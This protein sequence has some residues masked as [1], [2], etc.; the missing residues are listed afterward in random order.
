MEQSP[1]EPATISE[2][3][4][5]R[6][7]GFFEKIKLVL[8]NPK[9]FFSAVY[10]EKELLPPVIYFLILGGCAYA[11]LFLADLITNIA[12]IS[13]T[14]QETAVGQ[15]VLLGGLQAV[16]ALI[17]IPFSIISHL[18]FTFFEAGIYSVMGKIFHN[19]KP[20]IQD[21][22][23][24]AYSYTPIFLFSFILIVPCLGILLYMIAPLWALFLKTYGLK[25][26]KGLTTSQA[27]LSVLIPFSIWAILTIVVVG[28][29]LSL[30]AYQ[31][32]NIDLT[33]PFL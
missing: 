29:V 17:Y 27:V 10:H 2:S 33:S 11:V 7:L 22:K 1:Q 23:V 4:G 20:Y 32:D 5:Q 14:T 12:T 13:T 3:P 21:F 8:I 30:F 26:L 24:V 18:F 16:F 9:A 31:F 15:T 6:K 25:Q 28:L 19:E